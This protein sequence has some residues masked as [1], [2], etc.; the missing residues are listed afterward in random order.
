MAGFPLCLIAEEI[1]AVRRKDDKAGA[2]SVEPEMFNCT[3][4]RRPG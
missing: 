1:S 3:D 4:L 2:L